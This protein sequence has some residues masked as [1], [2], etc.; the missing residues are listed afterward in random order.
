MGGVASFILMAILK[1]NI[2]EMTLKTTVKPKAIQNT[3]KDHSPCPV[4]I[5]IG[6]RIKQIMIGIM[7]IQETFFQVLL[8]LT[9]LN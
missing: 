5:R 7:E 3:R 2:Q 6:M 9:G 4:K 8:A 1:R